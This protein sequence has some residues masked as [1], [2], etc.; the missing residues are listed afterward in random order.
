IIAEIG[1]VTFFDSNNSLAKFAGL[2]WRQ[3]QSGNYTSK[4]TRLTKTGNCYLRYY[5]FEAANS[6][7]RYIPEYKEYYW[8]KFKE[9]ANY[10]HKR[11][12]VFTTRKLVRLIFGLLA[13]N[14]IYVN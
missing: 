8:K 9:P 14:R 10:P 6:V 2:T 3:N 1:S 11:A 4:I 7:I 12:L 5:L 13:K